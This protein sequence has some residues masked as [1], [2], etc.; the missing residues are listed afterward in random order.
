MIKRRMRA[1]W[2]LCDAL[3]GNGRMYACLPS[4]LRKY[5][6]SFHPSG[7]LRHAYLGP[8]FMPPFVRW[9]EAE[10][11][12]VLEGWLEEFCDTA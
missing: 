3:D 1:D 5:A 4:S 7:I 2:Y 10:G 12:E 6:S 9:M 8:L 11:E